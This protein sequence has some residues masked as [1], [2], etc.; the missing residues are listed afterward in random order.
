MQEKVD[1]GASVEEAVLAVVKET[2][3]AHKRVVFDGDNY[4][5]DWHAE[6]ERRGLPNLT[7]TPDALPVLEDPG[8]EAIFEKFNVLN[9]REIESRVEVFAEQYAT[10][11]NIEGETCEQIARTMLLPAAIRYL[12]EVKAAGLE[13]LAGSLTEMIEELLFAI[14]KL[15]AANNEHPNESALGE[16]V[17]ARDAVLPAMDAVREAA[18]KLEQVVADDLWPLP[19]Y[20]EIL[21]V[22]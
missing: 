21:F 14:D 15:N 10:K 6:A 3:T 5:E 2:W 12:N 1:G 17:Y 18:D 16:A 13:P 19:K 7:S 8:V 11:V 9:K 22:K 4:S 20:S